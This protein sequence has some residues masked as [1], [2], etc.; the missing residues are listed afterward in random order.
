MGERRRE[1]EKE[2]ERERGWSETDVPKLYIY[3]MNMNTLCLANYSYICLGEGQFGDVHRGIYKT[4]S[5]EIHNIA[6]KTCK[7]SANFVNSYVVYT[8]VFW[9]IYSKG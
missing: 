8:R 2:R 7:V 1:T 4:K 3:T 9:C 6:V 5:G